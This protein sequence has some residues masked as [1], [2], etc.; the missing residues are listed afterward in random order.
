[1]NGLGKPCLAVAI[2]FQ[3]QLQTV[4]GQWHDDQTLYGLDWLQV[5]SDESKDMLIHFELY[6]SLMAYLPERSSRHRVTLQVSDDMTPNRLLDLHAV[7][8]QQAH[9]LCVNG[10]FVPAGERDNPLHEGD[11]VSVWPPVAGG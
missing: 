8:R 9:L 3:T 10:E 2:D 4:A 5:H 11:V 1:M 6:A 7:P